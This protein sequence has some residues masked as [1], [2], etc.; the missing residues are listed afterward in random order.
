MTKPTTGEQ[1][2]T[3]QANEAMTLSQAVRIVR[4][5]IAA[6]EERLKQLA[7]DEAYP[8]LLEGETATGFTV[9]VI[10][11]HPEKVLQILLDYQY[12]LYKVLEEDAPQEMWNELARMV[13]PKNVGSVD[14]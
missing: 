4:G 11:D 13:G 3:D 12:P 7:N 1:Q 8:F 9:R 2:S 5:A 10:I 6:E 14:L